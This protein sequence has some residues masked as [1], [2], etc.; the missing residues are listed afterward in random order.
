[1]LFRSLLAAFFV[2]WI[3]NWF[4]FTPVDTVHPPV[5]QWPIAALVLLVVWLLYRFGWIGQEKLS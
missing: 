5:W 3:L 1:V 4:V 2:N